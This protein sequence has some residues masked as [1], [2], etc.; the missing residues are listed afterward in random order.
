MSICVSTL[1]NVIFKKLKKVIALGGGERRVEFTSLGFF[2]K[3]VLFPE[4]LLS[5]WRG[6]GGAGI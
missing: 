5:N 4:S 6:A 2:L 3:Q 1:Q